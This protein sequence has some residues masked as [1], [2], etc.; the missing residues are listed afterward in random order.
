MLR[1]RKGK[2]KRK[3]GEEEQKEGE[4]EEQEEQGQEER[5]AG[6]YNGRQGSSGPQQSRTQTSGLQVTLMATVY[7]ASPGS[8]SKHPLA[9]PPH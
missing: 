1:R 2:G 6:A 7:L 8:I 4:Q 9:K 3:R 5:V